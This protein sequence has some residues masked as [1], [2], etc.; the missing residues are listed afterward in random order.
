MSGHKNEGPEKLYLDL[1]ASFPEV[2]AAVE[3]LG[4]TVRS[5]GP[6][7]QKTGELI[8][9]AA[10]AATRSTGSVRSHA[11]K[12]I[13]AG[14]K[15]EEVE[16]SLLLLVSTIGFPQVAAALSWVKDILEDA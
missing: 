2:L 8:Q 6:L 13:Q 16:H 7:D 1:T 14:A 3:N 11:R 5:A 15:R 12:A 4:E 10:A 9:L